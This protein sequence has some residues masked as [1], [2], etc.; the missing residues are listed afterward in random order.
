MPAIELR[1][2]P[3]ARAINEKIAV[4]VA[5]LAARGVTPCLVSVQVGEDDASR[6]YRD[7]QQKKA[8]ALGIEYRRCDLPVG[9]QAELET[10]LRELNADPVIHGIILQTPLPKG[11]DLNAMQDM[12]D[13]RKDVDGVT[14]G[15]LG[16]VMCGRPG[17]YPSTAQSA[18]ELILASGIKL[19]GA[20]AVI[21]GR[22]AIVGKP[23]AMMLVNERATITMCH[24]GTEAAGK[25]EEHVRRAEILVVAAGVPG[26]IPGSWVRPGAVVIDVGIN[27]VN[28]KIVGDIDAQDISERAAYVSPV[29][30][31]VGPLTVTMLLRNTVLAA[32]RLAGSGIE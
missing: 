25:L 19:K 4:D 12:I 7:Q 1:G 20:E 9:T 18:Y 31:G 13:P 14:A 23:V 32:E 10:A 24:T 16:A 2:A 3:V 11:Y 29:P 27:Y 22:S 6:I 15:N 21:I 28:D 26:L 8:A 17:L 5:A 30:G